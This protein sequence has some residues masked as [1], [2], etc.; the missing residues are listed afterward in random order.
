MT[1]H[2]LLCYRRMFK[3][4]KKR[5]I[6][7]KVSILQKYVKSLWNQL[8]G[9][10][11]GKSIKYR[12]LSRQHSSS[13]PTTT[14]TPPSPSGEAVPDGGFNMKCCCDH[15][16]ESLEDLVALKICLLGD[17]QIGKTSFLVSVIVIII[18]FFLFFIGWF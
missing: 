12:Q 14:T 18:M 2:L 6:I 13:S 3:L 10:C 4:N 8:V 16:K 5:K 1:K 7:C 9:C 15:S 11:I 17:N